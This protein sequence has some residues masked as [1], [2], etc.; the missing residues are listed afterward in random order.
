LS[1]EL[2]YFKDESVAAYVIAKQIPPS[3]E[4]P[5]IYEMNRLVA[6]FGGFINRA[7]DKE[8]EIKAIWIGLQRLKGFTLA[9]ELLKLIETCG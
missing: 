4:A 2:F 8:P 7:G 5:T 9:F 1:C 3:R 6:S